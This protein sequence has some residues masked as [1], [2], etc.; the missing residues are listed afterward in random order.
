VRDCRPGLHLS[1][2]DVPWR[3]HATCVETVDGRHVA[4]TVSAAVAAH[5][6]DTHNRQLHPQP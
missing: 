3:P 6:A 5:I 4:D 2:T 1:V